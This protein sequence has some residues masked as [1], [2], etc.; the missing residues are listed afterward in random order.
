MFQKLVQRQAVPLINCNTITIVK[1]IDK[2]LVSNVQW[3]MYPPRLSANLLLLMLQ[4]WQTS[5]IFQWLTVLVST[6]IAFNFSQL[7]LIQ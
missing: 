6:S 4:C 1:L 5:S 2:G 3:M 7:Q